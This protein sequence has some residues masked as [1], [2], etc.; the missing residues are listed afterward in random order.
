M[1]LQPDN[2]SE[3]EQGEA[4][5]TE[6]EQ[7]DR[8][9]LQ[10]PQPHRGGLPSHVSL[11]SPSSLTFSNITV[12]VNIQSH[13]DLLESPQHQSEERPSSTITLLD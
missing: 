3:E 1:I 9:Y 12:S 11:S 7:I 2:G 4:D 10:R 8:I 6:D 5:P 13:P